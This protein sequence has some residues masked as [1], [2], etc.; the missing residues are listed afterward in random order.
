MPA[1]VWSAWLARDKAQIKRVQHRAARY[2]YNTY[3]KYSSVTAILQSLY[4][5]TLESCGF[6]MHLCIYLQSLL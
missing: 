2:V 4:W 6:N 1:S 5:E 3:S